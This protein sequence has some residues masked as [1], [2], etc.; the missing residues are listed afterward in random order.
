MKPAPHYTGG[1]NH[2]L[3]TVNLPQGM[4][5]GDLISG[6]YDYRTYGAGWIVQ[7]IVKIIAANTT[8]NII[9]VQQ[10]VQDVLTI[11]GDAVL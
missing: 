11:N 9:Q 3:L 10:Q 4:T 2:P 1:F 6:E 7:G 8:R 5:L